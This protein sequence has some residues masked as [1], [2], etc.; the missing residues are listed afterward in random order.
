MDTKSALEAQDDP[1][2]QCD[3]QCAPQ[4]PLHSNPEAQV[5]PLSHILP[6]PVLVMPLALMTTAQIK[7]FLTKK[8]GKDGTDRSTEHPDKDNAQLNILFF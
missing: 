5:A 3:V 4:A 1:P 2:A 7:E 6:D 8:S